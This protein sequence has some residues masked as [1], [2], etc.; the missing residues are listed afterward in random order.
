MK[1]KQWLLRGKK[2]KKRRLLSYKRVLRI[3]LLHSER[4]G[5]SPVEREHSVPQRKQHVILMHWLGVSEMELGVTRSL[6]WGPDQTLGE[7]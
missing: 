3:Q 2:R 5:G 4:L 6:D 7:S 1:T